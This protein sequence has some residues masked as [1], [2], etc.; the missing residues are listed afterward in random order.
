MKFIIG[1]LF[2]IVI[3]SC[4]S[5][6]KSTEPSDTTMSADSTDIVFTDN[7]ILENVYENVDNTHYW[8]DTLSSF[9]FVKET[10]RYLDSLTNHK[11]GIAFLA[12]STDPS[13]LIFTAGYNGQERFETYYQFYV[14][15][16]T[17]KILVYDAVSD[18]KLTIKQYKA[19]LK[20]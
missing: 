4:T 1:A 7:K 9:S 18:K 14:E 11:H 12:D 2:A 16:S 8:M 3:F 10:D 13:E 19:L 5:Q 17:K 6:D 20:K 15:P